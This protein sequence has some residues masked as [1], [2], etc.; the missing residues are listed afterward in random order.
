MAKTTPGEFIQQVRTETGKVAWPSWKETYMTAIMV[1]IMAVV[2]GLF[3]F[4][5]DSVFSQIV[6]ALLGLLA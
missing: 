5:V 1:V 6:Q 3:F 2:L 4:L